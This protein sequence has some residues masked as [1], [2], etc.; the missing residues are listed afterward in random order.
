[1]G[2]FAYKAVNPQGKHFQGR[3]EAADV[4]AAAFSVK[5]MG[6]IPVSID[7]PATKPSGRSLPTLRLQRVTRK[8]ILFFTEE[9]ATLVR[10]GLPLDRSLSITRELAPKQVLREVIDDLL[11]QIK[12]GKSLAEALAA[13]SKTVFPS[14]REHDPRG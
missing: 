9:L 12:G 5:N 8:D 2:T 3:V 11:K 7:E 6:L 14:S 13:T 1:M 4:S 10:A